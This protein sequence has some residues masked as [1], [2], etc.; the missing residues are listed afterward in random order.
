MV[1]D[2]GQRRALHQRLSEVLG[3]DQ[4]DVLM[5]QLP[6]SGWGDVARRTDLDHLERVL[7]L[8]IGAVEARLRGEIRELRGEIGT[9]RGEMNGI[10]GDLKDDMAKQTRT[11][12]IAMAAMTTTF[13]ASL[14]IAALHL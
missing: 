13:A 14:S 9:L 3:V 1:V 12:V 7:H 11:V 2:E 10:R 5:E 6:P 4:A 8:E